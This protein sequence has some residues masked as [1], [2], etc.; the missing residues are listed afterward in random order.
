MALAL[1]PYMNGGE[2]VESTDNDGT[3]HPMNI[4]VHE[5]CLYVTHCLGEKAGFV[6]TI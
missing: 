4:S 3:S 6:G 2:Y 1:N 5:K